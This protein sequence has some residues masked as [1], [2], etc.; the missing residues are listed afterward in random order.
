MLLWLEVGP[1]NNN[2]QVVGG[3]FMKA[4]TKYGGM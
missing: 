3:Y 1:T 4:V 2:S